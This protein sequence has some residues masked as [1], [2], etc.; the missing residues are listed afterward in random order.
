MI[1]TKIMTLT[2]IFE[3]QEPIKPFKFIVT[4]VNINSTKKHISTMFK[5]KLNIPFVFRIQN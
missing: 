5:Q 1:L 3:N 4:E 2:I